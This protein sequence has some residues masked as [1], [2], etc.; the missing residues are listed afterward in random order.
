MF[1]R[2]SSVVSILRDNAREPTVSGITYEGGE[3]QPAA[4]DDLARSLIVRARQIR[5]EPADVDMKRAAAFS[6][7]R[8]AQ[9]LAAVLDK[10]AA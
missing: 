7:P 2:E 9:D 6:A 10:V 3:L 8:L 1:H 5:Y 4:V